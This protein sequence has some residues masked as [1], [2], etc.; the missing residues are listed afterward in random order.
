MFTDRRL[1]KEEPGYTPA[2]SPR[3]RRRP[4]P[5]PPGP[6]VVTSPEVA[7]PRVRQARTAPSPDPPGSSWWDILGGFTHRFLA[8]SFSSCSPG[9]PPSDG[10]GHA[11]AL[12]G[13]L[14]TLPGTSRIGRV[15]PAD[16]SAGAP[17][18]LLV[19]LSPQAAQASRKGGSG[20]RCCVPA[21]A[22]TV[23]A[24]AGSVNKAGLVTVRWVG[25]PVMDQVVRDYCL[26]GDLQPPSFPLAGGFG[27]LIGGQ[28]FVPAERASAV[29]PGEQ[30]Q[31]VAIQ[32]GFDASPPIGPVLGQGWVVRRRPTVDHDVPDDVGPGKP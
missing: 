32:R 27:W 31:R 2:A 16:C 10:A 17:S 15:G 5:W 26:P 6:A 3:L 28:Q 7:H 29:L 18:E 19:R 14:A 21:L 13:P 12:S 20:L 22:D 30:A 24:S 9:P 8:Y 11:P 23:F 1:T 4:S 25:S